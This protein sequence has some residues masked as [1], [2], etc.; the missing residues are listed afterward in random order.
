MSVFYCNRCT[1]E[2]NNLE[3]KP[4]T[5][6]CGDVFCEQCLYELYDK[7]NHIIICPSH[8]KEIIMEFNKIPINSNISVMPLTKP[9]KTLPIKSP[10][11]KMPNSFSVNISDFPP[12]RLKLITVVRLNIS[13]NT[14]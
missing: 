12:L 6:P 7:K 14:A 4:L 5:L 13:A 2:Y 11:E 1:K 3:R 10:T 8:K 9:S